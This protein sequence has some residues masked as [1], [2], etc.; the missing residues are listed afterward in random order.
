MSILNSHANINIQLQNIIDKLPAQ[1]LQLEQ[2]TEELEQQRDKL[3]AIQPQ[4]DT[5]VRLKMFE[6][7][8]LENEIREQKKKAQMVTSKSEEVNASDILQSGGE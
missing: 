7:P 1:K 3:R 6:I 5:L 2:K 4:W 8:E